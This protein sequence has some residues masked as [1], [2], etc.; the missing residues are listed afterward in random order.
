LPRNAPTETA[1][2]PPDSAM[3]ILAKTHGDYRRGCNQKPG[4]RETFSYDNGEGPSMAILGWITPTPPDA[5]NA[6]K[7]TTK[8]TGDNPKL[9]QKSNTSSTSPPPA[10][11]PVRRDVG[12]E[13]LDSSLTPD[14]L[15][16]H[17][18]LSIIQALIPTSLHRHGL[19]RQTTHVLPSWSTAAKRGPETHPATP[20]HLQK[21]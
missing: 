3:R 10:D 8:T 9:S 16:R 21:G 12:M 2:L 15:Q 11:E 5:C 7:Q 4:E 6:A 17:D 18:P 19:R 20:R 14:P 13:V 1:K